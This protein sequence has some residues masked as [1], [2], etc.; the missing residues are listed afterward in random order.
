MH[1]C[2]EA[3][4]CPS[5]KVVSALCPRWTVGQRT[6]PLVLPLQLCT[7]EF[8]A[9]RFGIQTS[10]LSSSYLG[11]GTVHG[12]LPG[13]HSCSPPVT[14]HV[15]SRC[16]ERPLELGSEASPCHGTHALSTPSVLFL[17][18]PPA[19]VINRFREI[20]E[21][22]QGAPSHLEEDILKPLLQFV[23]KASHLV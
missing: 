20:L 19:A 7:V 3:L 8:A 15:R 21:R 13:P 17:P 2:S 16:Q 23:L 12:S 14:H 18:P 5:N 11:R 22:C 4:V 6:P 9:P 10:W 1:V